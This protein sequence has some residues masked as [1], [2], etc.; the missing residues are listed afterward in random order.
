[1]ATSLLKFVSIGVLGVLGPLLPGCSE[2][3][4]GARPIPGA[5]GLTGEWVAERNPVGAVGWH[6]QK[7]LLQANG[8]FASVSS[9]YGLYEGQRRDDPSAWTRIEG[10]VRVDG[11]RL[12][13]SPETMTWWDHFES[14]DSRATRHAAYPWD[15]LF[16]DAT[17]AVNGDILV[18]SF[19]VYPADAPVPVTARYSRRR[20][21]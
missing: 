4:V 2:S 5:P 17:V 15:S 16:D 1:M 10:T 21:D 6:E 12:H 9:S 20:R 11:N 3:V 7:L 19:N 18:L 8:R 14:P 13:F